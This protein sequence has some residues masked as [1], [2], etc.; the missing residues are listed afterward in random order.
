MKTIIWIS[1]FLLSPLLYLVQSAHAQTSATIVRVDSLQPGDVFDYILIIKKN[2]QGAVSYPDS[3]AFG[4][5]FEIRSFKHFKPDKFTDSLV[6]QLQYFGVGDQ[7][8][9]EIPIYIT[10]QAGDTTGKITT[11]VVPLFYKPLVDNEKESALKP[12]KPIFAFAANYWIW[13]LAIVVVLILAYFTY[14]YFK[15]KKGEIL[16]D[17]VVEPKIFVDPLREFDRMLEQIKTG[18]ALKHGDFKAFYTEIGDAIRLYIERV[19]KEQALEMTTSEL[20][21]ALLKKRLDPQVQ[22]MIL[23]ILSQADRVK[24][25]KYTP[26][27]DSA[28]D[29]LERAFDLAKKF[30]ETDK[31]IIAQLRYEFEVAN[32][33]RISE[34]EYAQSQE[35]TS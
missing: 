1:L 24:F 26:T 16:V 33:L 25:A 13:I 27:M 19:Y 23:L 20:K 11:D 9:P 5:D 30:R 17:E 32:G 28:F 21:Y 8:L 14:R 10:N 6:F 22:N 4:E 31:S 7:Q 18:E 35:A 34:Q 29:D 3:S 12:L 2:E 15:N